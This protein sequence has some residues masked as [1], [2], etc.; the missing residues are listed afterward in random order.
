M[1]QVIAVFDNDIEEKQGKFR[2][3]EYAEARALG[4]KS[5][6]PAIKECKI[7]ATGKDKDVK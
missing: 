1:F 3:R 6:Y 2:T 5:H 4:L 7:V